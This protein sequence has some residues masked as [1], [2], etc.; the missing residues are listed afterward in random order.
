M[1]NDRTESNFNSVAKVRTASR[2]SQAARQGL[3]LAL[4][5]VLPGGA[6]NG[7][8]VNQQQQRPFASH[9]I[10][11]DPDT[12]GDPLW[13]E[14]RLRLLNA[15]RQKQLVSDTNKLLKLAHELDSEISSGTPDALTADQL[16]KL[17]DIEKLAHSVKDKM[18]ESVRG[19]PAYQPMPTHIAH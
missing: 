9:S 14:K 2:L 18:R 4:L 1:R 13:E 12:P 17:A 19:A 3:F 16:R 7:P 10:D 6:Q 8:P 5:F 15:D 11:N